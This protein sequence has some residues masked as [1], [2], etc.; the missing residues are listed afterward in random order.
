MYYQ[1]TFGDKN[2]SESMVD[3]YLYSAPNSIRQVRLLRYENKNHLNL[4]DFKLNH[5]AKWADFIS[6]Y[7]LNP[8][9]GIVV[10][11]S[12]KTMLKDFNVV[13]HSFIKTTIVKSKVK[14]EYNVLLI[15]RGV[16]DFIDFKSSQLKLFYNSRTP[17]EHCEAN[18][19]IL[20]DH[21]NGIKN[22]EKGN[23]L[24]MGKIIL[25]DSFDLDLFS[26]WNISGG[27][28]V[29]ERMKHALEESDLTGYS[30]QEIN[31]SKS[32]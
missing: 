28:I 31:I 14:K 17:I 22:Y 15:N 30:F 10:S 16:G 8:Y 12:F 23:Y 18:S 7:L 20:R 24:R 32:S 9:F 21:V 2:V 27:V 26:I 5:S 25:K 29:S 19:E 1:L 4:T 13:D 3:G 6:C 11:V